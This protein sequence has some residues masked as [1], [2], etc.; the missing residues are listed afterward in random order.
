M[1]AEPLFLQRC[2]QIAL[3]IQSDKEID[4]LDLGGR[5]RQLLMD[6]YSLM[7]TANSGRIKPKFHVGVSRYAG[8]DEFAEKTFW[9]I[10]DGID[11]ENRAPGAPSAHLT[12]DAFLK[13]VVANDHG[14]SITI[15]DV[16]E[17]TS[18]K[19]GGIHH[20]P[21][22]NSSSAAKMDRTITVHGFPITAYHLKGIAKVALRALQPVIDDVQ[23]RQTRAQSGEP[24]PSPDKSC[25]PDR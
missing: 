3:L 11:P 8:D 21:R 4:L 18:N 10:L 19:S 24:H 20:D 23:K 17:H 22:P 15:K 5:L 7:D 16:I 13:H 1:E 14:K 12:R 25:E 9:S 6:N 2:E